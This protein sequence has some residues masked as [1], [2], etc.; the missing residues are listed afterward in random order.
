MIMRTPFLAFVSLG[1]LAAC[2]GEGAKPSAGPTGGTFIFAA[3][4]DPVDV[5][6]AFVT[7]GNGG[8]VIDQVFDHLA[9]ISQDLK[10]T[11]DKT[12]TPRLAKSW[13]WAPD[14]L[15]IAFSLDPRAR[16]H[17][18]KPV[19]GA[20]VRYSF[21]VFTDPKA[22]S[23]VASTLLNVDSVSVKDSLTAVVWFK[24]HTRE[25]FYDIAYQLY[26]VPE[27]VYGSIPF[28][29]LRTSRAARIPIG[30]GQFRFVQWKPGV[31]LEL[32]ADTGNYHGRPGFDR[33]IMT[34]ITEPATRRTQVLTGQ[35][36]YVQNFPVDLL[37]QL[38]SGK[39]ARSLVVTSLQYAFMGM[40]L[41]APKSN[42]QAH[43]L[44]GDARVR[45]AVSMAIDRAAILQSVFGGKGLPAH[46]P[47]PMSLFAADS[48]LRLPRFDTAAA[49]A[50][51]DS[52]GWR[53]DADGMRSKHGTHMRFNLMYP[54]P[55]ASR[56]SYAVFIQE[57]LR[58]LGVQVELD[59]V[60]SQVFTEA[61]QPG[62]TAG[63]FD[64]ILHGFS[65]DPSPVG[66]RQ[67]W[68]TVGIGPQG[69]N[70]LRYSN[71]KVDG[72]IDSVA[73]SFDPAK[74]KQYASRAFQQIIDDAPAVWLYDVSEVDAVNRRITVG[75]LRA[76]G[77]WR[78]LAQWS[79]PPDKRIARDSIGL[80]STPR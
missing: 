2:S 12:F 11:G 68:G 80:T 66:M 79:I 47:F 4:G 64:A 54:A 65:T 52:A 38:D 41:Y 13:M 28:D 63:N 45:R 20:D 77:W 42:G 78:T 67:N 8:F 3:P 71:P 7:E 76:D 57:Q 58:R 75:P 74:V 15:S 10:T 37:P 56:H 22:A 53:R 29:S 5:F 14:S 59:G 35:A 44:F 33:V 17:D 1:L 23:P 50:L 18:G 32:D 26:V 62:K 55:S 39:V 61:I 6:P 34:P 30:S 60:D 16:W 69:Q 25:Q 24:K 72:L 9:D 48:T 40:N 31:R 43:P 21:K 51:L 19:T 27:H 49:S 70:F 36:D 46:G 73:S